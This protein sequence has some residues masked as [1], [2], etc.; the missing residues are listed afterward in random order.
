MSQVNFFP[1][2]QNLDTAMAYAKMNVRTE[3]ESLIA[4]YDEKIALLLLDSERNEEKIVL[5][6]FQ[7]KTVQYIKSQLAN[8][9]SFQI[10]A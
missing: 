10:Q 7:K 3:F 5:L 9:S 8:T 4:S 1:I 2:N 6:R